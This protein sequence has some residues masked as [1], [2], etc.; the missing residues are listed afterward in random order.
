MLPRLSSQL[1][2]CTNIRVICN[3]AKP[4]EFSCSMLLEIWRRINTNNQPWH[5][6]RN[7]VERFGFLNFLH[8]QAL[9]R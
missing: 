3:T 2:K 7:L 6:V 9:V 5:F 1:V 8:R 4:F